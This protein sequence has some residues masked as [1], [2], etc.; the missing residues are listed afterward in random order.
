MGAR[1][2]SPGQLHCTVAGPRAVADATTAARAFA[3]DQGIADSDVSRLCVVVEELV[4]NLYDHGGV[5]GGDRVDLSLFRASE[6]IRILL[7]D[8]GRPFDPRTATSSRTRPARGGG[9]GIAIVKAW[10]RFVDYTVHPG[11]NRLELF[12]PIE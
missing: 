10:T 5:T 1:E 12:M 8:T 7:G 9:A 11:G 4:A 3:A 6:G 2:S